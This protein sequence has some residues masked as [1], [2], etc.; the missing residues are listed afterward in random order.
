MGVNLVNLS[1][2]NNLRVRFSA[3]GL[4]LDILNLFFCHSHHIPVADVDLLIESPEFLDQF[5]N[6]YLVFCHPVLVKLLAGLVLESAEIHNL[7][8]YCLASDVDTQPESLV[9]EHVPFAANGNLRLDHVSVL[10]ATLVEHLFQVFTHLLSLLVGLL[11]GVVLNEE[12]LHHVQPFVEQRSFELPCQQQVMPLLLDKNY[13]VIL[14][15]KF[16]AGLEHEEGLKDELSE[17]LTDVLKR[18]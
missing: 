10:D 15:C 4:F 8:Y 17:V 5:V 7:V 14:E 18:H 16:F 1:K 11:F 2:M 3:L 9:L 12:V 13:I 6:L